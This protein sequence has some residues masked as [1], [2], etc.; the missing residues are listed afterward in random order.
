MR[1]SDWSSDVCSSDLHVHPENV[2]QAA[3]QLVIEVDEPQ[4][5]DEYHHPPGSF[6]AVGAIDG[7]H[8]LD[9][10]LDAVDHL[11]RPFIAVAIAH[12]RLD[13]GQSRAFLFIAE[14]MDRLVTRI[15]TKQLEA[16]YEIAAQFTEGRAPQP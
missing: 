15:A 3:G 1:I 7:V 10:S 14:Q 2:A 5:G 6:A 9:Q 13:R 16:H 8:V 4:Q 11:M 12:P